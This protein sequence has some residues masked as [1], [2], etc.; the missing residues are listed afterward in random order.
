MF[1]KILSLIRNF[2]LTSISDRYKK[3]F[4]TSI[5]GIN[6]TRGKITASTFIVIEI[7][8]LIILFIISR[9]DFLG[10]NYI[11]YAVMYIFLICVMAIYLIIFI[12]LEKN[13]CKHRISIQIAG[14][15]F[16]SIILIWCA[17][18]SLLDQLSSG[19][20][21]VYA[22][23]IIAIAVTP[24]FEPII[25]LMMYLFAH[26]LFI[27]FLSHFQNS[28]TILISNYINSTT[29]LIISWIISCIRY[30]SQV[31]DFN[32]RKIIQEKNDELEQLNKELGEANKRLE[33]LSQIDGL[34]GIFNR[35]MFDR[36]IKMEWYR[37]EFYCIPLSLIMI[38]IDFF[39]AFNDNY[40]HQAG[41][42]CIRKVS[43][44]LSTSVS[45]SSHI[46]ARYGG[47]EFAVILTNV[48]KENALKFAEQLRKS[49]EELAIEHMYS[50]VSKHVTISLGVYTI[51]PSDMLSIERFIEL[52]D[53]ALYEAKKCRNKVVMNS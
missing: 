12:E 1:S 38:D 35:L 33:K 51:V 45:N 21:I 41:D 16:T 25:L 26:L 23:S 6:V 13:I 18:I 7:F 17:G 15:I 14:I 2:L 19:Q 47:E 44:V 22:I 42:N 36:T 40:G 10:K 27:L 20:I 11:Y 4:I 31:D 28:N 29:I 39:K 43:E 50:S 46:A 52:T 30:K 5:N 9:G 8:Q 34:T 53:E 48:G 3:E 24:I 49:V 37:C 32:N